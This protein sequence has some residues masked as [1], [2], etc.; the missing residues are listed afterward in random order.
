M[1][2]KQEKKAFSSIEKSHFEYCGKLNQLS[3]ELKK[4]GK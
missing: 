3:G 4:A 2:A 1:K